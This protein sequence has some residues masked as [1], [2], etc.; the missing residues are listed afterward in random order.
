MIYFFIFFL[1]VYIVFLLKKSKSYFFNKSKN[2][3]NV[4]WIELIL[5]LLH[6]YNFSKL[7]KIRLRNA[8]NYFIDSPSQFDG[9]TIVKDIT[10][11][12]R[13]DIPAMG[14]DHA[15]IVAES[16]GFWKEL[17]SRLKGDWQYAQDMRKFDVPWT[18]AYSRM[19]LLIFINITGVY[20]LSKLFKK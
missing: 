14:H 15:Y 3:L 7:D 17:L 20:Y 16:L 1:L 13:L 8:Y 9:A 18:I 5:P 19:A 6:N 2:E 10:Q 12:K 4:I 11:I